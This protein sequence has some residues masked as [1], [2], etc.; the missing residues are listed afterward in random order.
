MSG[1]HN[2]RSSVADPKS[3][4]EPKRCP[5]CALPAVN[6]NGIPSAKPRVARNELPWVDGTKGLSTL[7][8]LRCNL[9]GSTSREGIRTAGAKAVSPPSPPPPHSK[10][11]AR[12]RASLE[13]PSGFGVRW[14]GEGGDTALAPAADVCAQNPYEQGRAQRRQRFGSAAT[15]RYDFCND[16]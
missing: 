6:P 9:H 15:R 14:P 11:L 3:G 5:R 12:S 8:E 2:S 16:E 10:R 1:Q 13:M 4:A 7:K